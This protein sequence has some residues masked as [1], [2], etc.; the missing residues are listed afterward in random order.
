MNNT[1]KI[2]KD[3]LGRIKYTRLEKLIFQYGQ[4]KALLTRKN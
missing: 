3:W 4:I 1:H 2:V